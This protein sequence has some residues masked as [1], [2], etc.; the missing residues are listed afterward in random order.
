[1][2]MM[3]VVAAAVAVAVVVMA[4]INLC[5]KPEQQTG[6]LANFEPRVSDSKVCA[7]CPWNLLLNL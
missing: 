1:M 7:L 2:M 4:V 6:K 5:F 3:M